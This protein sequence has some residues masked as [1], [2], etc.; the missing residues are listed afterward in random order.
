MSKKKKGRMEMSMGIKAV[1]HIFG[2][3]AVAVFVVVGIVAG[4]VWV[5]ETTQSQ[6]PY[7]VECFKAK[8]GEVVYRQTTPN[9]PSVARNGSYVVCAVWRG[10]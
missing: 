1:F 10:K 8:T 6:G 7:T 2:I 9:Y 3:V 5:G 4:I